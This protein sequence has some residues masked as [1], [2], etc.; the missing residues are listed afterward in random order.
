M[1]P[2]QAQLVATVL[3]FAH[4][5]ASHDAFGRVFALR[6]ATVRGAF[7]RLQVAVDGAAFAGRRRLW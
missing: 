5:I 4:G 3:P 1:G 2:S 7:D 6:N